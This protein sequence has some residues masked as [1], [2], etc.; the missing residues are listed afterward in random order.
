MH[1][2]RLSALALLVPAILAAQETTAPHVVRASATATVTAKPDTAEI[3]IGVVTEASTATAASSANANQTTQL[4]NSLKETVG[5]AGQVRTSGYSIT[6]QYQYPE[7]SAPRLTGYRASNSVLVTMFNVADVGKV[8]D[9]ATKAG[10]NNIE[11]I[12]FNLKNDAEIRTK[13]LA[14]AASKAR[15]EAEA[16]AKALNLKVVGV[17]QAESS[18]G[19]VVRPMMTRAFT[20]AM[21]KASAPTPIE[22]GDLDITASVVVTLAVQE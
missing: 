2:L 18:G 6:A 3:S 14:E 16:I 11:G 1:S 8:I 22:A 19:N 4:I 10:A 13:A 17:V 12:S 21:M 9:N 20:G 15:A 7:K 5:S